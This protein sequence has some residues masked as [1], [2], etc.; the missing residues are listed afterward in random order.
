MNKKKATH[1]GGSHPLA[2][3]TNMCGHGTWNNVR[4]SVGIL[5]VP[6]QVTE[7]TLIP[8]PHLL[9]LAAS[10]RRVPALVA[11]SGSHWQK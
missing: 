3:A 10:E 1:I 7:T 6:S 8:S 4:P 11:I 2:M 5:G 9:V